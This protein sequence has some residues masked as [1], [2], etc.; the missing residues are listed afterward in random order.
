MVAIESTIRMEK[1]LYICKQCGFELVYSEEGSA[2]GSDHHDEEGEE[3][4]RK[5]NKKQGRDPNW[6]TCISNPWFREKGE[7]IF[8]SEW[9]EHKQIMADRKHLNRCKRQGMQNSLTIPELI[10]RYEE[11]QSKRKSSKNKRIAER[12]QKKKRKRR[13]STVPDG[14]SATAPIKKKA[15]NRGL[16]FF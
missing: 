10:A 16:S 3:S 14:G 11:N 1:D 9:I 4:L 2:D 13:R 8:D 7:S 15:V 12:K 6:H 5:R